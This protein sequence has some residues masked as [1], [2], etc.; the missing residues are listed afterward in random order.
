MNISKFGWK[1]SPYNSGL[2]K[3]QLF[4]IS[5][6][7]KKQRE[8]VLYRRF[9]LKFALLFFLVDELNSSPTVNYCR[10]KITQTECFFPLIRKKRAHS[11]AKFSA[12][13]KTGI[14]K[15]FSSFLI[16]C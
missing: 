9:L 7:D 8:I 14:F 3:K 5:A 11:D 2:E 10:D 12:A 13:S 4:T 15:S 1:D 16:T 6:W